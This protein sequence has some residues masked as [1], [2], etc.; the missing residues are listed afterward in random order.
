MPIS[1][2]DELKTAIAD[3][4]N[5]DDLTSVIPSFIALAEANISR[6]LRDLRMHKR[7][8]LSISSQYVSLPTDWIETIRLNL[9]GSTHRLELVSVGALAD[10]RAASGDTP[11]RPTHYAVTAGGLEFY[12]APDATYDAEIVY[13]GAIPALSTTSATNWLLT[14]APDVYLYG[15]L[16][17][18]AP[19][20]KD[21]Q[22]SGVWSGLYQNAI[23]ALNSASDKARYSG[24]GLRVK[25]R[26]MS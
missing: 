25:I 2:F 14:A 24:T 4:L 6:D 17:Q 16:L 26:G 21:D 13:V 10:L 9:T 11:G 15:A 1:T 12:P 18:T 3:W 23:S 19:Y 22:R 8:S 20:L 7:S 5:R